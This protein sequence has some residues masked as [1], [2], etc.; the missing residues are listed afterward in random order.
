MAAM[1]PA[2]HIEPPPRRPWPRRAGSPPIEPRRLVR[3]SGI[4]AVALAGLGFLVLLA[5]G[6]SSLT[7]AGALLVL[8]SMPPAAICTAVGIRLF[9]R[10]STS[11]PTRLL[12]CASALIV[13]AAIIAVAYVIWLILDAALLFYEYFRFNPSPM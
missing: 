13:L 2:T 10:S 3:G 9:A 5:A 11:W 7:A 12:V 4:L 6:T 8:L 1:P